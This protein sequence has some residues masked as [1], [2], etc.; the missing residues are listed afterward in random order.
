MAT[1][2][3]VTD[4]VLSASVQE[5]L[6]RE[7]RL[8][9]AQQWDEWLALY[10]EDAVFWAPAVTMEGAYTTEPKGSLNFVYIEGRAGLDARVFRVKSGGSLASNPMPRTRHLVTTALIDHDGPD[11]VRTFANFQVVTFSEVRGQQMRSG[12][13]EHT[14]RKLNGGLKI[15]QKKVLLLEYMIDGYFDV[16][17]I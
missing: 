5:F 17:T 9:D 11:E 13:Y 15:A 1:S 6:A 8:L 4:P 12:S 16:F 2:G 3:A 14:L 7:A 10:C